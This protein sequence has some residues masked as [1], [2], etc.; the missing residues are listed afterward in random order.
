MINYLFNCCKISSIS[1]NDFQ[2]MHSINPLRPGSVN[3]V[4][5]GVIVGTQVFGRHVVSGVTGLVQA[6]IHGFRSK[7]ALQDAARCRSVLIQD[8]VVGSEMCYCIGCR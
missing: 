4:G 6:P 8:T 7:G 3:H 1:S 5:D 2:A